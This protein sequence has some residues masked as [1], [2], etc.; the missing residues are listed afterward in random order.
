MG[1]GGK[2]VVLKGMHMYPPK[3]VSS[4]RMELDLRHGGIEW[5]VECRITDKRSADQPWQYPADI[6]ALL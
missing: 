6:M 4:N 1:P 5:V 2:K 3:V